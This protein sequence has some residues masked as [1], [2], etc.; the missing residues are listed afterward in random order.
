M[1]LQCDTTVIYA[2]AREN[3]Y[4]GTLLLKDLKFNS[5]YNTYVYP[6]LPPGAIMNPG[7]ESL[8]AALQPA[9]TKYIYF[10]RT[11][12][13]RHTF[14]ETLAAHNKAVALYRAMSSQCRKYVGIASTC[15]M[16]VGCC[17]VR[18]ICS[19]TRCAIVPVLRIRADSLG[20]LAIETVQRTAHNSQ[21]TF[22]FRNR[23]RQ[24]DLSNAVP[25]VFCKCFLLT[26]FLEIPTGYGHWMA[27]SGSFH[28]MPPSAAGL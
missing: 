18:C 17:V 26:V 27:I 21:R 8:A 7:Y 20:H 25:A 9:K 16:F 19:M 13:G 6:G 3:K 24:V 2:L 10:V 4:R 28:A 11:N 15:Q 14:S 5:S 1:L 22:E 23:C 12:G